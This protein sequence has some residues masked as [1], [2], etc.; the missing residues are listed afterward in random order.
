MEFNLYNHLQSIKYVFNDFKKL[1]LF[2]LTKQINKKIEKM[3]VCTVSLVYLKM[4][5]ETEF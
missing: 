2:V 3:I 1:N 5:C 4:I